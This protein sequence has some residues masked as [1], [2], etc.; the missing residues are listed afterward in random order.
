MTPN[1][2]SIL[3]LINLVKMA[4]GARGNIQRFK[5]NAQISL[6][7]LLAFQPP[8]TKSLEPINVMVW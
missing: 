3:L 7:R 5:S 1:K 6:K 2:D 8:K 4:Q